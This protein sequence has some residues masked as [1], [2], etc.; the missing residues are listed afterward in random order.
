M[1]APTS[2]RDA[3]LRE[4]E[5]FKAGIIAWQRVDGFDSKWPG[6]TAA[7]NKAFPLPMV[8]RPR[9]VQAPGV[10]SYEFCVIDGTIRERACGHDKPTEWRK[11]SAW[12]LNKEF[13]TC[14][15]DLLANPTELV[16][17]GTP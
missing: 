1:S 5:A 17:E 4:R 8:E 9:V 6:I 2:E 3:V 10:P 15:A 12:V 11:P 13:V 7:A 16:E 14:W